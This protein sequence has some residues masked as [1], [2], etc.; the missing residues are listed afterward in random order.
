MPA[1][2]YRYEEVQHCMHTHDIEPTHE[3]Y[4]IC[5]QCG[6]HGRT[7]T[8]EFE[9]TCFACDG[10]GKSIQVPLKIIFL[11]IDSVLNNYAGHQKLMTGD[12]SDILNFDRYGDYVQKSLLENFHG[13]LAKVPDA[14]IILITSWCSKEHGYNYSIAK[15]LGVESHYFG[16]LENTGGG[17]GRVREVEKC[18]KTYQPDRF[19]VIDDIP[20][21]QESA[22]TCPFHVQPIRDGLT[23]KT[24][25]RCDQNL[26]VLTFINDSS[27]C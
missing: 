18:I 7:K 8:D 27:P 21:F 12:K 19:V 6:G 1:T 26:A 14:K 15:F 2:H 9:E 4:G 22:I 13:I 20:Y 24:C 23:K 5:S 16:S 10:D 17:F 25:R 3:Y 11:D